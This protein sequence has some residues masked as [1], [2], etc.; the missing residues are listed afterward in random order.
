MEKG[1]CWRGPWS[2]CG[3]ERPAEARHAPESPKEGP[4]RSLAG[5]TKL[6][7]WVAAMEKGPFWRGLWGEPKRGPWVTKWVFRFA[8]MEKGPFWRGPWS[9][10]GLRAPRAQERPGEPRRAQEIRGPRVTK[11]VFRAAAMEKGTVEHLRPRA[12]RAQE[13]P[14]EPRR[15]QDRPQGHKTGLPGCS[16]GERAILDLEHLRPKAPRAQERPGEHC[17]GSMQDCPLSMQ[18][19]P[20]SMQEECPWS[21]QDRPG[22]MPECPRS[23]Y[24][25]AGVFQNGSSGLQQ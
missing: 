1:P 12:P 5:V 6:V 25:C 24:A 19:C 23:I 13:K 3:R 2:T 21:M 4:L 17:P 20:G 16:N 11:R 10:C 8:A 9:T 14:D 22:S 18:Q 7:F 15:A